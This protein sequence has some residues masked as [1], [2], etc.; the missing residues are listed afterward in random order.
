M[1]PEH[2]TQGHQ[3]AKSPRCS[4]TTERELAFERS[5]VRLQAVLSYGA[6]NTADPRTA[7]VR[8]EAE[9]LDNASWE[10]LV[11]M[12]ASAARMS[13][14]PASYTRAHKNAHKNKSTC[15]S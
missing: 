15:A 7:F 4:W 1:C 2:G 8:V 11:D 5:G 10:A 12:A 13:S 9:L 3:N 14:R 6:L